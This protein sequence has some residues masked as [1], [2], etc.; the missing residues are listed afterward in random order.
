LKDKTDS[1][2]YPVYI[3]YNSYKNGINDPEKQFKSAGLLLIREEL[4]YV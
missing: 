1:G 4:S 2:K 3:E